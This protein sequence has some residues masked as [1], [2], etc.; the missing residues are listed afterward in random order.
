MIRPSNQTGPQ[1]KLCDRAASSP[2]FNHV[3][4]VDQWVYQWVLVSVLLC[5]SVVL[6]HT[7]NNN[8]SSFS[9]AGFCLSAA[10]SE[11]TELFMALCISQV[12]R[13]MVRNAPP[14]AHSQ[15]LLIQLWGFIL[16][17]LQGGTT[18]TLF[19]HK[20]LN[21]RSLTTQNRQL[22]TDELQR[23]EKSWKL[24]KLYYM[25]EF[26]REETSC[27]VVQWSGTKTKFTII[28]LQLLIWHHYLVMVHPANSSIFK[29]MLCL[30]FHMLSHAGTSQS[31]NNPTA[32][33]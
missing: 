22:D 10:A 31:Y 15:F 28:I 30:F 18:E 8:Q 23:E 33:L 17:R 12:V 32:S 24:V 27:S 21:Y 14:A 25:L 2:Q 4:T 20:E 11:R 1:H 29:I 7:V 3:T 9:S 19:I 6:S 13:W 5:G 16:T 26:W